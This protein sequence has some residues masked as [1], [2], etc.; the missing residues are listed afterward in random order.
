[1]K[2]I[3]LLITTMLAMTG[4]SGDE[5]P[6]EIPFVYVEATITQVTDEYLS[7][8]DVN[9]D[10]IKDATITFK[11][12]FVDSFQ[13][14]ERQRVKFKIDPEVETKNPPEM[15]AQSAELLDEEVGFY[16]KVEQEEV[17]TIID[18]KKDDFII[19]DVRTAK[20][21]N[22]GHIEGAISLP[23]EDI[24]KNIEDVVENKDTKIFLYG[25]NQYRSEICSKQLIDMEYVYVGDMGDINNWEYG[26]SYE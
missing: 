5:T 24:K 15:K 12:D 18:S 19:I 23:E 16:R 9:H 8:T 22:S 7:V 11:D 10:S 4:C 2:K 21:Y 13:F 25:K 26:L 6:E 14:E 20:E 17:K 3:I 1:M